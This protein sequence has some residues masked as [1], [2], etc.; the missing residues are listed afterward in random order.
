MTYEQMMDSKPVFWDWGMLNLTQWHTPNIILLVVL[1]VIVV[2]LMVAIFIL[3]TYKES[4][5]V[6]LLL[7]PLVFI[8]SYTAEQSDRKTDWKKKDVQEYLSG[9]EKYTTEH[10]HFIREYKD[11]NLI[12]IKRGVR[13]DFIYN[14]KLVTEDAEI[15]YKEEVDQPYLEYSVVDRSIKGA[16]DKG[17]LVNVNL[18]VPVDYKIKK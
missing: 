9:L 13:V 10:L 14:E 17:E 5:I 7:V 3:I 18:Y 15:R 6:G 12:D 1:G 11:I 16:N 8:A 2:G 4:I